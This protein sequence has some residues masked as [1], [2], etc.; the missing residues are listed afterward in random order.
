MSLYRSVAS[1]IIEVD[2]FQLNVF[3]LKPKIKRKKLLKYQ[4]GK[5]PLFKLKK[6]NLVWLV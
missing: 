5:D 6:I 3:I 1:C 4:G 2:I